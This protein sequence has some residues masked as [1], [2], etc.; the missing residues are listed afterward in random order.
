MSASWINEL[1]K[2]NGRLHKEGVL[3]KAKTLVTLGDTS[4]SHV[5]LIGMKA[6]YNPYVTFGVKQVLDTVGIVDAE[7]PVDDY[8]MLL[9]QLNER[10][11]TGHAARDAIDEMSLRFNSDDWN[12]FYA[13]ILRR[14]MRCGVSATTFNKIFKGTVYEIPI[15]QSQLATNCEGRPE[16]KGKKRLEPKLDGVRVLFNVKPTVY[17]V[18]GSSKRTY[19]ATVIAYS[20]NGKIF[21]NFDHIA[22]Q[23][24]VCMPSVME[25]VKNSTVGP[26][27]GRE[28]FY[29]DGE[30][31][32]SSFQDLMRQA[33]RKEN[34]QAED[35]V[36]HIF[37]I[38]P[39]SDFKR[40]Y[41]NAQLNKRINLLKAIEPAV[42]N[43]PNVE[44][45]PH[46]DVDLDTHEGKSQFERYCRDMVNAGYEGV[47]IKDLDAPY[48]CKRSTAWLKYKPVY[49]YDLTVIG[50][51]AGKGKHK[52]RMGA[53][54]C[55]G[56]DDGK[57]IVVNVGS[58]FTDQERHEYWD[59]Q[60]DIIGRTAVVIAD[61]ITLNQNGTYSLR[62][63]RFKTFRDDK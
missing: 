11:L 62:F 51:E 55:E 43:M 53:L 54:I 32:S 7:N 14:D 3:N 17:Y 56:E 28:G 1:N 27:I 46:I 52:G 13:P 63:P 4:S 30:V 61:A 57:H 22:Q 44:L 26:S 19:S 58:G 38:I 48:V 41:W 35:S 8:F 23:I 40:G 39:E 47:L 45:L 31:V 60:N 15:F 34:V 37:D 33:R 25:L 20:R 50:V 16:M 5:F 21:E 29:L 12:T 6:C 24:K 36:F 59:L 42:R 2:E 18:P 49:D 9:E 10:A